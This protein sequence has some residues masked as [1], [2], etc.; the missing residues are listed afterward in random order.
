[1]LER[2][3]VRDRIVV[4]ARW[5]DGKHLGGDRFRYVQKSVGIYIRALLGSNSDYRGNEAEAPDDIW[6]EISSRT[7]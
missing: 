5:F 3:G 6:R 2:Q 7:I 4:V 1:M